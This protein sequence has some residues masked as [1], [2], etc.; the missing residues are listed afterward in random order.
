VHL[1]VRYIQR[2]SLRLT[3]FKVRTVLHEFETHY[4]PVF[5]EEIKMRFEVYLGQKSCRVAALP[6][7]MASNRG[8]FGFFQFQPISISG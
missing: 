8:S 4:F 7:Q 2:D 6:W 3:G 1:L 5:E